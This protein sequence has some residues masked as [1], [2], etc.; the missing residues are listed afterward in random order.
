MYS[1]AGRD[2][3][4]WAWQKT[5]PHRRQWWRRRQAVN[6]GGLLP[7]DGPIRLRTVGFGESEGCKCLQGTGVLGRYRRNGIPVARLL[8]KNRGGPGPTQGG[9]PKKNGYQKK[10]EPEKRPQK[11]SGC[12]PDPRWPG[13]SPKRSLSLPGVLGKILS[14]APPPPPRR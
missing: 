3:R 1:L 8:C 2:W 12:R 9:G 13:G 4:Q 7:P 5:S 6:G 10:I 14:I 11:K